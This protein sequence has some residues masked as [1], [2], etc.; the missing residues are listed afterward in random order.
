MFLIS[1]YGASMEE[2]D[3]IR[4]IPYLPGGQMNKCNSNFNSK[5]KQEHKRQEK[6]KLTT[7]LEREHQRAAGLAS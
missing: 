1:F 7:A 3:I 5:I 4:W 2:N 6:L